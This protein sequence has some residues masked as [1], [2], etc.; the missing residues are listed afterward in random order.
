MR[1]LRLG[2]VPSEEYSHGLQSI[3]QLCSQQQKKQQCRDRIS[4]TFARR[5]CLQSKTLRNPLKG[6]PVFVLHAFAAGFKLAN[7]RLYSCGRS[8]DILR[9]PGKSNLSGFTDEQASPL[10]S[11]MVRDH[12]KLPS[13]G[14]N[15]SS[16]ARRHC[17]PKLLLARSSGK[18]SDSSSS[19]QHVT[20]HLST[21]YQVSRTLPCP[22]L[23][24]HSQVFLK[25]AGLKQLNML[26]LL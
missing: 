24:F 13:P 14:R 20:L 17:K 8:C 16:D 5:T 19:P 9:F 12:H 4:G 22:C 26:C 1:T 15:C 21:H 3:Q 10:V 25:S 23:G 2:I 6:S 11:S 7:M 18:A